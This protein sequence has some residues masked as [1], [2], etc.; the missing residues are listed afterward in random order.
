M[1]RRMGRPSARRDPNRGIKF[2]VKETDQATLISGPFTGTMQAGPARPVRAHG[3]SDEH[4]DRGLVYVEKQL[5]DDAI[6]EFKKSIEL[7]PDFAEGFNNLGLCH[8]YAKRYN[9]AIEALTQAVRHFPGWHIATANLGL[10]YQKAGKLDKAIHYYRQSVSKFSKQAPVWASL[11]ECLETSGEV[12][13]AEEAYRQALSL[14]ANYGLPLYRLGMIL[15]RKTLLDE[16]EQLLEKALAQDPSLAD[17]AGV[18]GAIQA[19]RGNLARAKELWS[20]AKEARPEKVPAAATRGLASIEAYET[21][22]HR[23]Y[24]EIQTALEDLPTIAE[25]MFNAGLAY[26]QANNLS[27]ARSSFQNAA[28]ED[29]EWAEPLL[30]LGMIEA[31]Q[32]NPSRSREHWQKAK[33][34]DPQN[35]WLTEQLGLTAL[36]LGLRQ[37]SERLFEEAR[38]LGREV[39]PVNV[40]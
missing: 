2:E 16:A 13:Q 32:E 31:L 26:M 40:G 15:A 35:A 12:D 4:Q 3:L 39:E 37:E 24:E 34:L 29:T 1:A 30:W 11:G 7:T 28:D 36:A 18:L 38:K 14:A 9:E 6:A 8:I 21:G 19:R 20:Q 5:W 25:C 27:M 23:N 33:Q 22:V 10:S 17:A